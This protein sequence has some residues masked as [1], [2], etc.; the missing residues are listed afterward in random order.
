MM[1][2]VAVVMWRKTLEVLGVKM[3]IMGIDA[4]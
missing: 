1:N 3:G 2:I 4:G